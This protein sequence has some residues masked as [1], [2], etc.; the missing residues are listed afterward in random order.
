MRLLRNFYENDISQVAP[1]LIGKSLVIRKND[2][3]F[4]YVIT[5][6]EAYGGSEDDASHARFGKTKRNRIMFSKGGYVYVYL[7][8]GIHWMLNIVTGPEDQPQAILIRGLEGIEGPGKVAKQL[9]IDKTFY[10]EDLT[11]SKRIW[12]ENNNEKVSFI[13]KPRLGIDYACEHW[14]NIKWRYI[15]VQHHQSS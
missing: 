12:I 2:I 1:A 9:D 15:R 3:T 4:P 14:R 6:V 8:Y 10:G 7:I 5:E 11:L 13:Q